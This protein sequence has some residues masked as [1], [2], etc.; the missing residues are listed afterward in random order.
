MILADAE[1][2]QLIAEAL[3]AT[4]SQK[5]KIQTFPW[6]G[7]GLL[8]T[9]NEYDNVLYGEDAFGVTDVNLGPALDSPV[10]ADK[11]L[12]HLAERHYRVEIAGYHRQQPERGGWGVDVL[13]QETRT[14]VAGA[15]NDSLWRAI[16]EA[17]VELYRNKRKN[18]G[19]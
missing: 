17:F 9:H 6:D 3:G 13:E 8:L 15:S 12:Q 11:I 18:N 4:P 1:K 14:S 10:L 5:G 16:C 2:I 19:D 7:H